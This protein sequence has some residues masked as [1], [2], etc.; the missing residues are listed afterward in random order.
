MKSCLLTA[1]VVLLLNGLPLPAKAYVSSKGPLAEGHTGVTVIVHMFCQDSAKCGQVD[2]SVWRRLI[3]EAT[4][5]WNNAGSNFRF[6]TRALRADENPCLT[7][8]WELAIILA[9]PETVCTGDFQLST[10]ATDAVAIRASRR[11]RIYFNTL[12]AFPERTVIDEWETAYTLLHELGH[13]IGLGHPNEHGQTVE[14]VMNVGGYPYNELQPDDIAGIRFLYGQQGRPAREAGIPTLEN[15]APDSFQSGIGIISGWVC[16]AERVRVIITAADNYQD[17][18]LDTTVPYGV[19][20][21]DTRPICGDWDNGFGLLVNWNLLGDGD[22][23][24]S[25]HVDDYWYK[26]V[27]VTVT[28]LGQEFLSGT[29]GEYI[30][31]NFPAPGQSVVIEWEE[32]LQNF[33]IT[34]KRDR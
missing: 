29:Q 24:V 1:V 34:G 5:K 10:F 6:S 31:E 28:T 17:I 25:V 20:R 21:F 30:L 19:P 32:S 9:S 22:Y 16:Q 11:A 4:E 33:V 13:I 2:Q 23:A 15:P 3:R 18:R 27:T 7:G 12:R 14:A 8:P 26:W